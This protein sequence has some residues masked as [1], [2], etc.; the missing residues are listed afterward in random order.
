M[1]NILTEYEAASVLRVD[2]DDQRMLDLLPLVDGFIKNA[3]G[4]DWASDA[5]VEPTAKSAARMLLVMWHENPAMIASYVS[6]LNFGLQSA[7]TQLEALALTFR[8]VEGAS[9][10]GFISLPGVLEGDT[11]SSVTGIIGVSG[12]QSASF[13]TVISENGYIQQLSSDDLSDKWF[14]VKIT[15]PSEL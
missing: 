2:T 15:K 12:D 3:T 14:R 1:A 7:L 11:V 8:F 6:S 4:Y 9:S 5:T 10:A 13:E